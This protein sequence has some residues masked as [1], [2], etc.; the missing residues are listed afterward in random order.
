LFIGSTFRTR[1]EG[2]DA[3]ALD[4][5]KG[6]AIQTQVLALA[7]VAE[8][9]HRRLFE[10]TK[11]V[12]SLSDNKIGKMRRAA[13]Q[14]ALPVL[15]D[16]PFNDDDRSEFANAIQEAFGHINDQTF[17][18]RMA[19][20]LSD[21]RKAIPGIGA[22]FADWPGAVSAARNILVHQPTLPGDVTADQFVDLLIALSYS[23]AWVLRTNLLNEAGIDS[24]TLQEAYRESSVYGHHIANT[25][26][27][28]EGGP[29]AAAP[30]LP[31]S[32]ASV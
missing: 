7:A 13:R 3:A 11:R 5:L 1:T 8:G 19:D 17:L 12:P 9:L 6:V 29:Y 31:F 4:E 15:T 22:A 30:E 26:T 14:A 28:L 25:R 16:P 27:L 18:N 23:I 20:L 2:L 32:G 24:R 10:E 21:A